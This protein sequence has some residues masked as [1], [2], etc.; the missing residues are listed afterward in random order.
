M[1]KILNSKLI[2]GTVQ[3]GLPYGINNTK[4]K[5]SLNDSLEIL[6]YAFNNDIKTLDSAEAYGN[7]HEVIGIFHDKNPNKIFEVI[8][9][10]P[11]KIYDNIVEKV[12]KYL[13]ELKVTQ[14]DTLMFH[15]FASYEDN[16]KNFEVLKS[17]KSN[18]KIKNL[19]VSVYTN[20]EIEN[21]ILNDDIDIIQ[22][23]FNL[24]DNSNLRGEIL[25]KAKSKGIEI[26]TR[27][28]FLQGLFFK[29][30]SMLEGTLKNLRQNL[31]ELISLQDDTNNMGD[32]ALN[33]VCQQKHIDKVLIGVDTVA[34]LSS[35]VKS[36][37]NKLPSSIIERIDKIK[38]AEKNV[39]S[40][41][42]VK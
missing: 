28:V 11:N 36:L 2:L 26:H 1:S 33:Y 40:I 34:Q 15:S 32:L 31:E 41:K 23:P 27:S 18:Q 3:M 25:E 10:L 13:K 42:L 21:V 30:P 29:D 6:E 19:G 39:K 17:L 37:G 5:V 35:N 24:F 20:D 9:K 38:V 7:A 12:D 16:I 14:L 22:L 8:T 4:G